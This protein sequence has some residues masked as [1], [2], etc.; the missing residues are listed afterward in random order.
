M[1]QLLFHPFVT[2]YRASEEAL[3]VWWTRFVAALLFFGFL[4]LYVMA[5]VWAIPGNDL[6]FQLSLF[7]PLEIVLLLALSFLTALLIVMQVFLFVRVGRRAFADGGV[8]VASGVMATLVGTASCLGCSIG[9]VLGFLG[10]GAVVFLIQYQVPI[11]IGTIVIFLVALFLI[12]R[13]VVGYCKE[14]SIQAS[15]HLV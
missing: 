14:C 2:I 1:I 12:G 4:I 9:I 11:L 8:G 15:K 5:P 7:S 3:S 13:R 6:A 10:V